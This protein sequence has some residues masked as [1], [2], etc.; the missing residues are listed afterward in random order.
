MGELGSK[1]LPAEFRTKAALLY[2]ALA[3]VS[4]LPHERDMGREPPIASAEANGSERREEP[5][6]QA[7]TEK[8]AAALEAKAL[9][10]APITEPYR[11]EFSGAALGST[12]RLTGAGWRL[13]EG[14]ICGE[15]ARNHPAWLARKLPVNARIEFDAVSRS[16]D[17]DI[18]VEVWGDGARFASSV[19]YDDATSY[20]VIFGGWKNRHHVLARL[21]EHGEDRKVVDL[22]DDGRTVR[23]QKVEP[24][25]AY[26]FA[27]ERRDGKSVTWSVDGETI[28]TFEDAEP[29]MGEG[30]DHFGFNN[31]E[32]QVCFDNL[33]ITPL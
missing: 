1:R 28:H 30:H 21:D 12:W 11:E 20:V 22:V 31:W 13:A 24:Q 33:S 9:A 15:G 32:V 26:R 29:L 5:N 10:D 17:G 27:I 4:C 3:V 19:S 14:Q 6:R 18:K 23:T 2:S 7:A 8:R 25:K 16:K